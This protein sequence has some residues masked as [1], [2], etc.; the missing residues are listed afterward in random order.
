MKTIEFNN[1]FSDLV[2]IA[3]FERLMESLYK[4]T[5]IPYGLVAED[6]QLLSQ[7]G[8]TNACAL[9]HR[10]NPQTNQQCLESNIDLM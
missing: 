5:G 1:K 10:V 2:D 8:W 4:A 3:A 9:F 7:I 6:G